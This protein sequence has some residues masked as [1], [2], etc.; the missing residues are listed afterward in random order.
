MDVNSILQVTAQDISTKKKK[1]ITIKN[2]RGR[3]TKEQI[4]KMILESEKIKHEDEKIRQ[5]VE[6]KNSLENYVYSLRN[7][8]RD[9]S[10]ASKLATED[11]ESLNQVLH[12]SFPI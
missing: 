11:K 6:A 2:E 1:E 3:L 9:E 8:I 12:T 10:L 5:R 7:S 4:D